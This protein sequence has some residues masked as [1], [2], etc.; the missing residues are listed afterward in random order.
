MP[1][2]TERSQSI[3]TTGFKAIIHNSAL[4]GVSRAICTA[5][6]QTGEIIASELAQM[7]EEIIS[8]KQDADS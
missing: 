3:L 6:L 4:D 2:L 7:R 5:I 1:K 8:A